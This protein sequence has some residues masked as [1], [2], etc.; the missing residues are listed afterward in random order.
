MT[1]AGW[2]SSTSPRISSA[3]WPAKLTK[4]QGIGTDSSSASS[5]G[6]FANMSTN[7]P[8]TRSTSAWKVGCVKTYAVRPL[9]DTSAISGRR[10]PKWPASGM[11]KN[12]IAVT[13]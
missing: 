9:R 6:Y 13:R 3:Y 8:P 2:I 12:A 10:R 11:A 4:R 1:R 7:V 5:S